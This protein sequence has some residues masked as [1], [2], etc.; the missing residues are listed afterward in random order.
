MSFQ[1]YYGAQDKHTLTLH[2]DSLSLPLTKAPRSFLQSLPL[3]QLPG[4]SFFRAT[5]EKQLSK[6]Q[7][8]SKEVI[9]QRLTL[10]ENSVG[11]TAGRQQ[12]IGLWRWVSLYCGLLWLLLEQ[13]QQDAGEMGEGLSC[14]PLARLPLCPASSRVPAL[15]FP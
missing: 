13:S 5:W 10:W 11:K 1:E 15:F 6:L 9:P 8:F 3:G 7:G 2:T 4:G 12:V 14:L